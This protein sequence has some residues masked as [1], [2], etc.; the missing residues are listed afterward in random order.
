MVQRVKKM[1]KFTQFDIEKFYPS[2]NEILLDK[3]IE[4]AITY[5]NITK[6][7]INIIKQARKTL[8][9]YNNQQWAKLDSEFDVT[10]GSYDGAEVCELVG[11]YI[12][13]HL[14]ANGID[15]GLYRDDGLMASRGTR[16]TNE[17]TKKTI[18]SIFKSLGLKITID[19]N[20]DEVNFLDASYNLKLDEVRPYMKEGNTIKYVH[21][22][23][24]HPYVITKN[25]PINVNQRI[26]SLSSNKAVFEASIPPCQNALDQAGYKYK[27][28]YQPEIFNAIGQNPQKQK[29]TKKQEEI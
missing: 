2:I 20:L 28:N 5:V 25:I 6:Q 4:W 24:N 11:L 26:N 16:R 10:M 15:A 23:S 14:K 22:D 3:S 8:L 19:T 29:T 7:E 27:L 21:K 1:M 13:H 12:L 9:Y 17:L 18:C